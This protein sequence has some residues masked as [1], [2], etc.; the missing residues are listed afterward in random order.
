MYVTEGNW[1]E[2]GSEMF[3]DR[4]RSVAVRNGREEISDGRCRIHHGCILHSA[5]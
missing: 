5:N 3:V 4:G 2:H 1:E